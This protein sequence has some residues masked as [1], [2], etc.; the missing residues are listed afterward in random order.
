MDEDGDVGTKMEQDKDDDSKA[1]VS[2]HSRE[3]SLPQAAPS[4]ECQD[5]TD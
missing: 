2:H 4:V 3:F 1:L 5:S